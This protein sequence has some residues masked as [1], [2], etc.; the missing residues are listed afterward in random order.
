MDTLILDTLEVTDMPEVVLA[1]PRTC[2]TA[3]GV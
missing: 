3:P 1:A 2:P